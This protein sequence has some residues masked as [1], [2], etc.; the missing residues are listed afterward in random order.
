LKKRPKYSVPSVEVDPD[1]PD[2]RI[3]AEAADAIRKGGVAVF[4][5][6]G[7]YGLAA[8]AFNESAVARIFSIKRRPPEKPIL[9]LIEDRKRLGSLVQKIPSSAALL[10]EAFWP[11]KITILFPAKPEIAKSLT[12]GSGKIGIRVPSHPVAAALVAAVGRAITGTSANLSGQGGCSRISDLPAAIGKEVDLILNAGT[13][14]AGIGSTVVDATGE[15]VRLIR[16]GSL[17]REEIREALLAGS[18]KLI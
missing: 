12:A 8:D 17:P 10:A 7:L 6:Q 4:P 16:E 15:A 1:N 5:T 14:K 18:F 11:G 3:I 9:V 13:L 2:P